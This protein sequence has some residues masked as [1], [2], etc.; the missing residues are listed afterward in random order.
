[1]KWIGKPFIELL[2]PED[3]PLATERFSN[4]LK[5]Q[6]SQAAELRI[7]NKSGDYI[8]SEILAS[9]QVKEGEIIGILGIARDITDRKNVEEKIRIS[10]E[11]FFKLFYSSPDAILVTELKSGRILEVN[12]SFEKFSGFSSEELIGHPVLEFNMYGPTERQRFV[13]LL[14]EKGN[15]HD[16]EFVLKNKAGQELYVLSSAEIIE[17]EGKPHTLTILKD[18]TERKRTEEVLRISE[19][20]YRDLIENLNDVVFTLNTDGIITYISPQVNQLYSYKPDELVGHP[21]TEIIHPDD[22]IALNVGFQATLKNFKAPREF[23][24]QTKDGQIRWALTSS[25][26]IL[27]NGKLVGISGIFSDITKRKINEEALVESKTLLTSII[28]STND[29]IWSVDADRYSLLTFNKGLKEFFERAGIKIKEGMLLEEILPSALVHKLKQLYSQTLQEGSLI[30]MYQTTINNRTLWINLHLLSQGNKPYAI[31]VFAKDITELMQAEEALIQAKEKA[32]KSDQLKTAFMNNISHEVRT[33]LNGILGFAQFVLQPNITEEEKGYYLDV[34]NTSSERLLNTITDY[35][36]IS[37]IISGN[38]TAR[39]QQFDLIQ[40]L[41]QI[42]EKF[43]IKCEAKNLKFIKQIPSDRHDYN[44]HCD[45]GLL[46]KSISHLV[47]N[48]IKFTSSGRVILGFRPED[49]EYELFVK[50]T[51]SGINPQA[52]EK[53]FDYYL[54]ISLSTNLIFLFFN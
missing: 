28:N 1:M 22:L 38:I 26:P 39:R 14:Q 19:E 5:G 15:I 6:I 12:K 16:V 47:D 11:K 34:L 37:L 49:K 40:L 27:E 29:L 50:D 42:Y 41:N 4:V 9:E 31:S 33:P 18:I 13:S 25:R 10:E 8:F 7:R 36:D 53:I 45:A 54:S 21:F 52:Q 46:E 3:I 43:R 51:G 2:H 30:T 35:M 20:K 48:A 32:E 44:L 23:R 17:I 24:Y